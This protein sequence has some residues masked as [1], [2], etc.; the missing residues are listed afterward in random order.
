MEACKHEK[1]D[2]DNTCECT[3]DHCQEQFEE[4]W[5]GI[6]EN[7][8]LCDACGMPKE[9]SVELLAESQYFH[10]YQPCEGCRE[11]YLALMAKHAMCIQCQGSLV[12]NKC[13]G[14]FCT[15]VVETCICRQC[16]LARVSIN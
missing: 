14:C 15:E 16:R 7:Q 11:G 2:C 9:M 5:T 8:G 13:P 10:F 4:R 6:V 3:C 12:D 1:T